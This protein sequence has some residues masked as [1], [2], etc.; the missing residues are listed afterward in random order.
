MSAVYTTMA[1][2]AEKADRC[3]DMVGFM[4]LHVESGTPLSVDDRDLFSAAFKGMLSERRAAMR[5][6]SAMVDQEEA[7]G[8]TGNASHARDYQAKKGAELQSICNEAV[9]LIARCLLPNAQPGEE[10]AFFYKMQGDYYRYMTEWASD[11]NTAAGNAMQAYQSGTQDAEL[12]PAIHPVRLGLALNFSVFLH[13]I[14]GDTQGAINTA[15]TAHTNAIAEIQ[16]GGDTDK[17]QDAMVTMSLLE[18]NLA[19][20]SGQ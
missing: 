3:D 20:W 4:K 19:L 2:V 12:L 10:R 13:E 1:L 7:Q 6:I 5:V 18:D 17:A 16:K 9:D 8:N 14:Y 15:Q 11:L